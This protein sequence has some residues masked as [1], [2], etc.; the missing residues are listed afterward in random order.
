M[1][2]TELP[3]A[4]PE[5]A[6][7]VRPGHGRAQPH[8]RG[9]QPL[10][11]AAGGEQ[12][13]Q[14]AARR[15]RRPAGHP[16]RLRRGADAA[17]AGAVARRGGC[18]AAAG[19]LDRAGDFT[20]AAG[21]EQPSCSPWPMRRRPMLVPGLVEIL[22]RDAP[23]V[24]VRVLPLTTRDPRRLLDEGTVD[25]AVGFFPA[26]LADLTAQ[27]QGGG[28]VAFEHERLYDG[29]YVCVMRKG[30]PLARGRAHARPLLRRA[31]HAGEL[32]RPALRLHRRGAGLARPQAPGGA[33][34]E[35]VLHRGPRRGD[36][37]PAD[38]AA[39]ATSSA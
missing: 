4:G 19:E 36:L 22:E 7:G 9:P 32:L 35:P 26:V 5:P 28:I 31:P 29:V 10:D 21:H 23:G 2:A 6:A 14:P 17:R 12:C 39:A 18:L 8:A 11:D 27:A 15:A 33:D 1:K 3:H 25:L 34:G 16:Q 37:R 24:S 38:G 13:A 20:A 30:H